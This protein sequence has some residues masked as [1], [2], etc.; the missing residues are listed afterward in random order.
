MTDWFS[1][2]GARKGHDLAREQAE[3]PDDEDV[4]SIVVADGGVRCEDCNA[5]FDR[6][7]AATT[8]LPSATLFRCPECERWTE[9]E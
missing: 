4:D 8:S 9:A 6:D 7:A 2:E 1:A 5:V 3:R